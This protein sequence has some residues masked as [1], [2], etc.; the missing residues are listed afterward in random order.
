ME[1][2]GL[3]GGS[4]TGKSHRAVTLAKELEVAAIIDDG[5]L[6]SGN[7]ILAGRSAK[8]EQSRMAAVRRA[9]FEDEDHVAEVRSELQRLAPPK[10]LI[11]G[12]SQAMVRRICVAL[13]IAL[14]TYYVDIGELA[15]A[16]EMQIAQNQRLD[17]GTH[18]IPVANAE[19]RRKIPVTLAEVLDSMR[20][21][22]LPDR[23]QVK[24]PFATNTGASFPLAMVQPLIERVVA[25]SG[26]SHF[27]LNNTALQQ[28]QSLTLV[29][30]LSASAEGLSLDRL[31]GMQEKLRERIRAATGRSIPAIELH[32][33]SLL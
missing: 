17:Q 1:I 32:I 14:P 31:Q 20:R 19:V 7:K 21:N 26:T 22:P 16:E 30:D 3:I 4:G 33:S 2:V 24:P 18:V 8:A 9:I 10:L 12:T 11:L 6:I 25:E 15:T 13:Q 29:L 28:K 23:T 5:L 27:R